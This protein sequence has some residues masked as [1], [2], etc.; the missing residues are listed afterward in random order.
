MW[1]ARISGVGTVTLSPSFVSKVEIHCPSLPFET[2]TSLCETCTLSPNISFTY[3]R[4]ILKW[5]KTKYDRLLCTKKNCQK[6]VSQS[7]KL[8]STPNGM[9]LLTFK[10]K[11]CRPSLKVHKL[12]PCT[13]GRSAS[14]SALAFFSADRAVNY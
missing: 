9:H 3:G 14:L 5:L 2:S 10:G 8:F 6:N 7:E 1:F 4:I 13:L 12:P 11:V